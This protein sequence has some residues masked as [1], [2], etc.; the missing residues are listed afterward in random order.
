[1]RTSTGAQR[2]LTPLEGQVGHPWPTPG[3]S[4]VYNTPNYGLV[5]EI[6]KMKPT[7]GKITARCQNKSIHDN[8]G[9]G[10]S[11]YHARARDWP[12]STIGLCNPQAE[13]GAVASGS[14]NLAAAEVINETHRRAVLPI[15]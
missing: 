10:A 12:V 6:K 1:S 14:G 2:G 11:L 3:Q 7:D 4:R 8:R 5:A 13:H 9:S 15:G